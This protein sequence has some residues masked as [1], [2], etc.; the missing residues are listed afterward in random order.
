LAELTRTSLSSPK[1]VVLPDPSDLELE[2]AM[3]PRE[4]FFARQEIVPVQES[5]GRI[6][7]EQITPYPPGIPAIVPGERI[8]A[9]VIDY[10]RSGVAATMVLPDAADPEF[11]TIRVVAGQ[12]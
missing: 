7:V 4:A 5:P 8:S 6:A 11:T 2:Q 12:Q 9:G 1:S 10:L 3:L